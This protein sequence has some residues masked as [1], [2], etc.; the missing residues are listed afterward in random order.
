MYK[1]QLYFELLAEQGTLG[2]LIFLGIAWYNGRDLRWIG[3]QTSKASR[4]ALARRRHAPP[5]LRQLALAHQHQRMLAAAFLGF[6]VCSAF[7]S[8]LYYSAFW[9]FTAL[10]VGLRRGVERALAVRPLPEPGSAD[11]GARRARPAD[12]EVVPDRSASLATLWG[13]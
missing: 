12:G 4:R 2:V 7:V 3:R 5:V 9:I 6:F 8:T 11:P 13:R 10:V 1:R